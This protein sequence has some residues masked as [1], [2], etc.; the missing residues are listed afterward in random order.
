MSASP[1][2][3]Q[4]AQEAWDKGIIDQNGKTPLAVIYDAATAKLRE[5]N[6]NLFKVARKYS[7]ENTKLKEALKAAEQRAL[8]K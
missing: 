3:K 4:F 2:A 1:E 8:T 6:D 7:V 5:A